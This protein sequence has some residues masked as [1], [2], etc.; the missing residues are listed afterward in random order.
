MLKDTFNCY[1]AKL[2]VFDIYGKIVFEDFLIKMP[3][4]EQIYEMEG[5]KRVGNKTPCMLERKLI[6]KELCIETAGKVERGIKYD[7]SEVSWLFD[8]YNLK[9]QCIVITY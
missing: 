1:F 9:G 4:S 6:E 2:Q 7:K 5:A 8:I 3:L